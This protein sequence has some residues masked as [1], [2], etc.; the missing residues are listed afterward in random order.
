MRICGERWGCGRKGNVLLCVG[1]SVC[2]KL[3]VGIEGEMKFVEETHMCA[4]RQLRVC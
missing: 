2:G 4:Q 1:T 3:G